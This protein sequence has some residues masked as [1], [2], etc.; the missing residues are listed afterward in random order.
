MLNFYHMT[1][2]FFL[3]ILFLFFKPEKSQAQLTVNQN[4]PYNTA[5]NLV[6]NVL[7]GS[8]VTASNFTFNGDPLQIGVFHA[9]LPSIG[10]DSGIVICTDEISDLD[11]NYVGVPVTYFGSQTQLDLLAIANSVPPLIGQVFS[12]TNLFDVAELE[13]D[14]VPCGS[15]V[16]FNFVFGSD[17]YL[18]YVNSNYND[19]FAFFISGPGIVG[20]YAGG[21]QN[22]AYVP[23]TSPTLPITISSVNNVLNSSYYIDNPFPNNGV[24]LNGYT[25]KIGATANVICGQ[26]YHIKLSLA[27]GEDFNL[28]SAIFIEGGSFRSDNLL[29]SAKPTYNYLT[30]D[31]TL[32]EGCG[33][34][35]LTL[36]RTCNLGGTDTVLFDYLGTAT[37]GVD[38]T[39]LP[40][41]LIFLPGQDTITLSFSPLQDAITEG[42][43]SLIIKVFSPT[44]PCGTEPQYL[45]MVIQD[46]TPLVLSFVND[47]LT[48]LESNEVLDVSVLTGLPP[49]TFAWSTG[50]SETPID[51][52]SSITVTPSSTTTYT[53]TVTDGCSVSQVIQNIEVFVPQNIIIISAPDVYVVCPGD[54]AT[55]VPV[56]GGGGLAPYQYWWQTLTTGQQGTGLNIPVDVTEQVE[57]F[58]TDICQEDTFSTTI[59]A[60]VPNY[61][62]LV[63]NPLSDIQVYCPGSPVSAL[64]TASGGSGSYVYTWD[65]WLTQSAQMSAAPLATTSYIVKATDFCADDTVSMMIQVVVPNYPPIAL[66]YNDTN[67]GCY[68]DTIQQGFLAIGG[69]GNYDYYLNNQP[70][71]TNNLQIIFN[72]DHT[73]S[74]RVVDECLTDTTFIVY[75]IIKEPN[76]NFVAYYFDVNEVAFINH[77]DS[78]VVGYSWYFGDGGGSNEI[79]PNHIYPTTGEYTATLVVMNNIGCL[80]SLSQ[81]IHSPDLLYIPNTFTPNDDGLNDVW[82]PINNG[83]NEYSLKIYTRWGGVVF[84]TNDGSQGW[85]GFDNKGNKAEM[86]IYIYLIEGKG[87]FENTQ[88]RKQGH[89]ML[90]R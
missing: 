37:N 7:L 32:Y 89:L 60:H 16:N 6:Q 35:D 82:Y 15:V 43:D 23:G 78:D 84:E 68:G 33:T 63:L 90:L 20:P 21:A 61:P 53:V 2:F 76:A 29:L 24:G 30:D 88:V 54:M 42:A 80:D 36:S 75:N 73:I 26:T 12:V 58:V 70:L 39:T 79:N 9:G 18:T 48:C 27:D 17:E 83:F 4:P 50:F 8:G 87:L 13:F 65:N 34:V 28:E 45:R 86:A 59:T 66:V 47:T 81:I 62:P 52:S 55:V 1:R 40:D 31:S 72:N 77:S 57:I 38:F 22:I 25:T 14:F 46:H 71:D 49:Y 3:L 74:V 41:T 69:T 67:I 44:N 64:A 10:M 51:S 19:V 5:Q 85:D 56:I 11:I